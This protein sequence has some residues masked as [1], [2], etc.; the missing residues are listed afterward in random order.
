MITTS[1]IAR[2]AERTPI[3]AINFV[4]ELLGDMRDENEEEVEPRAG[5]IVLEAIGLVDLSGP[6]NKVKLPFLELRPGVPED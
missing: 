2:R 4:S 6:V 5:V 3:Q 1:A